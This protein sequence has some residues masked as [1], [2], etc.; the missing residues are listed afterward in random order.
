MSSN[1]QVSDRTRIAYLVNQY[2]TIS[3]T[4]IRNEI[5]ELERQGFDVTRI[6]VRGWDAELIDEDDIAEHSKTTYLLLGG[7]L[8]LAISLIKILFTR[9]ISLFSAFRLALKLGRSS[10][11]AMLFHLVYLAEACLL[12]IKMQ[13]DSVTHVH[14]HFGTNSTDVGMLCSLLGKISYS[15]T[16]HGS[17][18]FDRVK[19]FNLREK[20]KRAEFVVA[21]SAFCR[22]QIYRFARQQ[23]WAKIKIVHCGLGSGFIDS[24]ISIPPQEPKFVS[25]GR[26]AE[27][28]GQI[29][30]IRACKILADRGISFELTMVGDGEMRPE[31]EQEIAQSGL[32][33]SIALVGSKS[34]AEVREIISQSKAFVLPSFAEGLPV[35]VMEAMSLGRPIIS[36]Y[37]AAI[38]ELVR[39]E[40]EGFLVFAS[41]AEGL[42]N[43]MERLLKLDD[44]ALQQMGE[45]ARIR[46]EKRHNAVT[47]VAKLK[48]HFLEIEG[49]TQ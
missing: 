13:E 15:F 35:V 25:V 32:Q 27:Q 39:D 29:I 44:S 5:V 30:L 6:S 24:A 16:I 36:T 12:F 11:R 45:R 38:P 42:A 40:S 23:D 7:V 47:E 4:F 10:D 1:D 22:S 8:P 48:E 33:K 34:G 18:E 2:P 37:I 41:D 49:L 20:V 19:G 31:I 46:A 17:E 26:F 43:A 3:H 9:P 28:K 21:I 14:C